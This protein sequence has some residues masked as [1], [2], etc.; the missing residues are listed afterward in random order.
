MN[1]NMKKVINTMNM[2]SA[3]YL[4]ICAFF[5][6][7]PAFAY[8]APAIPVDVPYICTV[9]DTV[10]VEHIFPKDDSP[11]SHL[12]ICLLQAAKTASLIDFTVVNDASLGLYV[13]SV[14]GVTPG[15]TEYWAIWENGVMA[16]CGIGCI[17]LTEWHTLSLILTDWMSSTEIDTILFQVASLI[18]P[19]NAGGGGGG[20][21]GGIKHTQV[22]IMQA[23]SYLTAMQK[24]DGSFESPMLTDWAAI[25]LASADQKGEATAKLREHM[26]MA[27]TTLVSVTEYERRAMA[28][29]ALGINPY[30][31]T[32][33]DYIAPIIRAFDGT[34][35]GDP[36]FENDDIFGLHA[37]FGAGYSASDELI[38]ET[39]AFILSRQAKD[40]SWTGGVDM[41][42]AAVQALAQVR[43]LPGVPEA[44]MRAEWYLRRQQASDGGYGNSFATSWVLQGVSALGLTPSG[45]S[46][47]TLTPHD[48]LASMQQA[49]GGF[50]TAS[51]SEQTRLWATA[52]AIPAA[53]GKS[54]PMILHSVSK[55]DTHY[56]TA[57][58]VVASSTKSMSVVASSTPDLPVTDNVRES[59]S[60]TEELPLFVTQQTAS[61]EGVVQTGLWK[62]VSD[63]F[64]RL[65]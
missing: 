54:W 59:R 43:M 5:L 62:Y 63:F 14:N 51:S 49:D 41:T 45:W 65:F 15:A 32:P 38:Q 33:V 1:G 31:G 50:E 34:Q 64:I 19:L 7:A 4:A 39:V 21:G 47:N 9:T 27:S 57:E 58:N 26:R 35:I 28:L 16:S 8:A 23:L 61:V 56:V 25:A 3:R 44:L 10:G 12:A 22:D 18:Q 36:A 2:K 53:L 29:E 46:P 42:G 52:Y 40:G 6:C 60:F 20:D 48:Y 30:S 13:E 24:A 17:P 11:S 37:L 55:P